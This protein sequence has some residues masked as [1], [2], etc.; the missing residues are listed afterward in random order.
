MLQTTPRRE[1]QFRG[2]L[3][4]AQQVQEAEVGIPLCRLRVEWDMEEEVDWEVG[5]RKARGE[6]MRMCS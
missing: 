6:E 4:S 5:R 2:T 3:P 1:G